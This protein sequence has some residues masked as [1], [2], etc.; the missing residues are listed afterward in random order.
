MNDHYTSLYALRPREV[1]IVISKLEPAYFKFLLKGFATDL[2]I[3]YRSSVMGLEKFVTGE[4]DMNLAALV[5]LEKLT[6][7]TVI[8]QLRLKPKD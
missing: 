2:C 5:S 3:L 6:L 8:S 7:Q 1:N 4:G